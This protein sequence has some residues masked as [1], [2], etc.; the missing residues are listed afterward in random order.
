MPSGRGSL[1]L[2]PAL[3]VAVLLLGFFAFRKDGASMPQI[4]AAP[5]RPVPQPPLANVPTVS[6][7]EEQAAAENPAPPVESGAAMTEVVP[8]GF[9]SVPV[10][11][12]TFIPS[13]SHDPFI[14]VKWRALPE[15]APLKRLVQQA[16]LPRPAG[17]QVSAGDPAQE[18]QAVRAA[19]A[20]I[21]AAFADPAPETAPDDT[22]KKM[23]TI[24]QDQFIEQ[25]STIEGE[26]TDAEYRIQWN[27][28]RVIA[29][30]QFR[31]MFGQ[32]ALDARRQAL[33]QNPE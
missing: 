16:A 12:K 6:K 27:K 18:A 17:F 1:S 9:A 31:A 7:P 30:S 33:L 25:V 29:D 28:A 23:E 15:N 5:A 19:T 11:K 8:P 14:P 2:I 3:L 26:P 4:A 21:P 20:Q 13:Y 22:A 10:V 24:I 32:A